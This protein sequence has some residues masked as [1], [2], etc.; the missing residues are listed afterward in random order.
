MIAK[1]FYLL[2]YKF[3]YFVYLGSVY[4]EK[5]DCLEFAND[6]VYYEQLSEKNRF[7]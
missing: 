7:Y 5:L 3:G 6:Y 1:I 2:F 4:P